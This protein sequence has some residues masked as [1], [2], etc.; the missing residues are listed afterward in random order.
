M[1]QR[2]SGGETNAR[3]PTPLSIKLIGSLLPLVFLLVG[4]EFAL[5]VIGADSYYKNQFFPVNRDID[6]MDVYQ[7]DPELFWRFRENQTISSD[8]FSTVNYQINSKGFRGPEPD[9][10]P[11]DLR[12]LALGNSCTFGW[13][14]PWEQSWTCRLEHLIEAETDIGNVEVI[15]AG[16][17]GYSSHQGR[18][19]FEKRLV[20]L[21]PDMVLV[22]FGWND[23]WVA[24]KGITDADHKAPSGWIL[25][26]HNLA[27]KTQL[28]QFTRK[29]ILSAT[30][31]QDTV[32]L[33]DVGLCR[34]PLDQFYGNLVAIVKAARAH[35]V[36]PV[37]L[38]PPVASLRNYFGGASVSSFHQV[39]S[40]YQAEI[41]RVSRT[42][43]V[44]M[45]DLQAAFDEYA[46]LFDDARGD[47][48]HYN[49]RGHEVVTEAV[50]QAIRARL[51]PP[52]EI[53]PPPEELASGR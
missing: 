53:P 36:E 16:V 45:V 14:V 2:I 41:L 1:A 40:A 3:R 52:E 35:D 28:F 50:W 21:R 7:R 49:A 44:L 27:S 23:H 31:K 13:G 17:P 15:N 12:I 25:S 5:R 24:G 10:R 8:R 42:Q 18:I 43:Q 33:D 32:E 47:A 26:L 48:V 6:F 11:V 39:H 19:Y 34:V 20:D 30:D 4:A 9:S 46:D 22:T 38:T 51:V 29:V 37:L